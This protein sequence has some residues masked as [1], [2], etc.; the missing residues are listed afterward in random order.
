MIARRNATGG[1]AMKRHVALIF[2]YKT[3]FVKNMTA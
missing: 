3:G 1:Q 2:M